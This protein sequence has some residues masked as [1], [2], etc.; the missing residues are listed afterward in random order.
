MGDVLAVFR[1]RSQAMDFN[2]RLKGAGVRCV[3]INTPSAAGVGCGLSVRF[4]Y[5]SLAR[6]QSILRAG[7]Y[8]AF[9]GFFATQNAYGGTY[10]RRI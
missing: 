6:V 7:R 8:S 3:L 10:F 4:E 2:A 5:T 1:S 9:F